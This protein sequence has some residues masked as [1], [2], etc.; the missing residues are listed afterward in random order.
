MTVAAEEPAAEASRRLRDGRLA[1]A[2]LGPIHPVVAGILIAIIAVVAGALVLNPPADYGLCTTCHTRDLAAGLLQ[3][4]APAIVDSPAFFPML[5]T[6]GILA[7]AWLAR[8]ASGERI[9][10]EP[11]PTRSLVATRIG[12]GFLAVSFA[13]LAMGCPIRLTLRASDLAIEGIIGLTGV[14]FGIWAGVRYLRER[15]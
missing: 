9:H 12:Q 5:T 3:Q 15:A 1:A 8:R 6:L 14:A 11:S 2:L 4:V 7:G 13:L 10:A